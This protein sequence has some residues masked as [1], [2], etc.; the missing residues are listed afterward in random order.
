MPD[1][2]T[3][4]RPGTAQQRMQ[5]SRLV[6]N[7]PFSDPVHHQSFKLED[8]WD[9]CIPAPLIS[10][11]PS[12]QRSRDSPSRVGRDGAFISNAL[13]IS[14]HYSSDWGDALSHGQHPKPTVQNEGHGT[15]PRGL[16]DS[17]GNGNSNGNAVAQIA[18]RRRPATL[19][20]L[21]QGN[22]ITSYSKTSSSRASVDPFRF[23]GEGYSPF[24]KP[25]AEK[26][27]SM[28]L[29]HHDDDEDRALQAA[30]PPSALYSAAA[31]DTALTATAADR[32]RL[33]PGSFYDHAAIQS[34]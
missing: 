15:R 19:S 30:S 1:T 3:A 16:V 34:T 31:T 12:G 6:S 24:L 4:R 14:A 33:P 11:R 32:H 23:D 28:A 29:Y 25:S 5:T 17:S 27:V 8:A 18:S 20:G 7:D 21:D 2:K 26:D 9:T 10:E 22:I 13:N